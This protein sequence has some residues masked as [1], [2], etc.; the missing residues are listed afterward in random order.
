[1]KQGVV[2]DAAPGCRPEGLDTS[3]NLDTILLLIVFHEKYSMRIRSAILLEKREE[4]FLAADGSI[5][6]LPM[7][8]IDMLPP[9]R[10]CRLRTNAGFPKI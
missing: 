5:F 4:Y 2:P 1:M 3:V 9:S 6:G 10:R 7:S 8:Q